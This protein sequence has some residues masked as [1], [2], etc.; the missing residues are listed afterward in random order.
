MIKYLK[1]NAKLIPWLMFIPAWYLKD[2]G[3]PVFGIFL[4]IYEKMSVLFLAMLLMLLLSNINTLKSK[5]INIFSDAATI[6]AGIYEIFVFS[7][8]VFNNVYRNNSEAYLLMISVMSCVLLITIIMYISLHINE[9]TDL[10]I[11]NNGLSFSNADEKR[12]VV[13]EA[14]HLIFYG[15]LNNVPE[16]KVEIVDNRRAFFIK[17][18]L[19][20]VEHS[21]F[22]DVRT[23]E[24]MEWEMKMILG[25][26]QLEEYVLGITSV[27]ASDDMESWNKLAIKYLEEGFGD[28]Y[29]HDAKNEEEITSNNLTLSRLKRYQE[30]QVIDFFTANDSAVKSIVSLIENQRVLHNKDIEQH[31]TQVESTFHSPKISY[32]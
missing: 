26:K 15:L 7:E 30:D 4:N 17:D 13:H 20:Y 5:A 2:Q 27:G 23:K 18:Y 3:V 9:M 12:T 8:A 10:S 24:N 25:G 21:N 32:S 16:I 11:T 14:G 6:T 1:E 31:L 22:S 29:Y 28:F 19:G